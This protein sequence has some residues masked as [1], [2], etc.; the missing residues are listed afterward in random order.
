LDTWHLKVFPAVML[1]Q[2]C[3]GHCGL[4]RTFVR[5]RK[6][7]LFV[8][9]GPILALSKKVWNITP[10][11]LG[12]L[13]RVQPNTVALYRSTVQPTQSLS[14]APIPECV[15]PNAITVTSVF[16]VTWR[17][18]GLESRNSHFS[19]TLQVSKSVN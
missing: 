1:C 3:R 9:A 11:L 17:V 7:Y 18:W 2:S 16:P 14:P 5:I 13:F 19:E 12:A 8:P 6:R 4:S 15:S 10:Y